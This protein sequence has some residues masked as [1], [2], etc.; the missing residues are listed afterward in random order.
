MDPTVID[1]DEKQLKEIY[2]WTDEMMDMYRHI[3]DLA[4]AQE[5]IV[6]YGEG[7]G[8]KLS[9][10]VDTIEGQAFQSAEPTTWAQIKESY[11][12]QLDYYADE[13]NK[14]LEEAE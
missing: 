9:G 1:I 10:V 7:L 5:T 11:T 2:L 13:L 12:E 8:S 4:E 3:Y 6:I 14:M